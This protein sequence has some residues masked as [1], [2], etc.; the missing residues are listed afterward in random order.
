MSHTLSLLLLTLFPALVIVAALSDAVSFTIPNWISAILAASFLPT[1]LVLGLSLS[2]VGLHLAIGG[3]AFVAAVLMFSLGWIGG[4]DAKLFAA[5][6]LWLGWPGAEVFLLVTG[7]AGGLL[8]IGLL[9]VRAD[10]LRLRAHAAPGWVGRLMTPDGPAP[11][12]V[13]IACGA[14]F[15]FPNSGLMAGL[16]AVF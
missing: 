6:A 15:A 12:G 11:Y 10:W 5:A 16:H 14:L 4:G 2:A 9:A 7:L 1:A 3:G 13:A 8:A